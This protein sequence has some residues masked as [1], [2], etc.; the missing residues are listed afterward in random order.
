MWWI[1]GGVAAWLACGVGTYLLFR[2]TLRCKGS[3][4]YGDRIFAAAMG[5][6]L[7]PAF[8]LIVIFLA[9]TNEKPAKW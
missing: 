7:A 2:S 8:L 6:G 4:T 5:A 9:M 1:I 3:W